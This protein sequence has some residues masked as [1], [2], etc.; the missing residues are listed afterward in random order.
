M[1]LA[2]ALADRSNMQQ[3]LAD[4]ERR[5]NNNAKVQA[6]EE[7]AE[8]PA[9]LLAEIDEIVVAMEKLIAKINLVN[10]TTIVDGMTLTE[11]LAKRDC[12]KMRVNIMRGFLNNASSKVDRY[13]KTEIAIKS[14]V[15]VAELQKEVDRYSKELREIDEKIQECNWTT[16]I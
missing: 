14:T 8:N 1:K 11:L 7:P 6:G 10:S 16:E 13:T 12:L 9:A 4:L 15:S 3:R 5:L 2:N